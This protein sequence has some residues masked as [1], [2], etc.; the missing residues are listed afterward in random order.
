MNRRSPAARAARLLLLPLTAV[1]LIPVL[2]TELHLFPV[3]D[4]V[5]DAIPDTIVFQHGAQGLIEGHLPYGANFLSAPYGHV[6]FVYPPL[7][8]LLMVPPLLAGAWYSFGFAIEMLVLVGIG[9]WL[10]AVAARRSG[11]VFPVAL[12]AAALM[13][14]VGPVLVTRVDGLQ[15]LAVAGAAL[16]LRSGRIALAVALVTLAA[17]VKE[18]VLVAALPIVVWALWPPSGSRWSEGLGRRAAQVGQGLIPSAA[19]LLTF[20]IWSRGHVIAAAF[21]SVHRGVEIESVPATITYLLQPLFR[22]TS[23]TGSIG[24]VQLSGRLVSPVAAVVAV[25]GVAALIWGVIHFVRERRRPITAVAF[26]IAVAVAS[27]PVLS[28]QYLLALLPVLA[29]AASTEFSESRANLL[30][31]T[32]FLMAILTQIEFPDLFSSVVALDPLAMTILALRNLLLIAIA[33]NLARADPGPQP[34]PSPERVAAPRLAP[35]G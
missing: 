5:A 35:L 18:T 25:A 12:T 3:H 9:L 19:V 23:Y 2:L 33:V 13:I 34:A 32:A 20:V 4:L 7:S 8:L 26:A 1:A 14:A 22:I 16:A 11:I 21:A 30:L 28:P 15:G 31:G 17:V 10:F 6:V 29:L 24:S 27:T